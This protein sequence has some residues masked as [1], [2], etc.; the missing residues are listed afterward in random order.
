MDKE[1]H[2]LSRSISLQPYC[3]FLGSVGTSSFFQLHFIP[4]QMTLVT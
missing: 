3:F 4:G 2:L 1:S